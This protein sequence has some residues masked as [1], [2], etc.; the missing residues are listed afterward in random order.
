M[1]TMTPRLQRWY[2]YEKDCNVKLLKMLDSVPRQQRDLSHFQKAVDK[3]AHAVACR[4]LWLYR[5]GY[6]DLPPASWMPIDTPLEQLPETL[7]DVYGRWDAFMSELTEDRL[8]ETLDYQPSEGG[9]YQTRVEDI[10]MQ[11]HGHMLYHRG[12]VVTLVALC[13]AAVVD[14][15]YVFWVRQTAAGA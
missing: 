11:L 8:A 4:K 9:H 13:G 7:D 6:I 2:A 1:S 15:D 3:F 5:L 14:T 12:Q 10:L